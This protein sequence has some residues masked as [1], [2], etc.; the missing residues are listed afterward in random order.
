MNCSNCRPILLLSSFSKIFEKNCLQ[1]CLAH[2]YLL[3]FKLLFPSQFDFQCDVSTS[4]AISAVYDDIRNNAN[5]KYYSC[6]LFLDL[7][8]VFD[9][10]D[11]NILLRKM[12]DQFGIRKLA[13]K[14]FESYLSNRFQY[15]RI[16]NS[17][18]KKAKINYGGFSRVE[19]RPTIVHD[20]YE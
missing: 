5:K 6:C 1:T 3:K 8:K 11:N 7:P 9:T 15:A 16:N 2:T 12:S 13:N 17:T 19:P 18:P 4:H 20:V 10:V 14:F